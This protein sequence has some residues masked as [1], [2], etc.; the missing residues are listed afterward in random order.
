[1]VP[2]RV[3]GSEWKDH[4]LKNIGLARKERAERRQHMGFSLPD[5]TVKQLRALSATYDTS[6][7][8]II[9]ALIDKEPLATDGTE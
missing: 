2:R 1:M 3:S 6:M 5:S 9:I 7:T 8:Q 4:M